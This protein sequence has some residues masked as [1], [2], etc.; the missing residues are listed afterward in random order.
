MAHSLCVKHL[1]HRNQLHEKRRI[2]DATTDSKITEA[3]V[4]SLPQ[5][6]SVKQA[7]TRW[8]PNDLNPFIVRPVQSQVEEKQPIE[9]LTEMRQVTIQFINIVPTTSQESKLIPMVNKAFQTVCK[10]VSKMRGVVNKV[11]LFDKD[12]MILVL[13]GLRGIEHEVESQNALK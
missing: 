11:S 13:F 8:I 4:A 12:C 10:I 1:E 6:T 2:D 9:Y 5:R 7:S 3:F